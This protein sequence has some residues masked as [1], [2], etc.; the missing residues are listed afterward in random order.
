MAAS[1]VG[2]RSLL[3]HEGIHKGDRFPCKLCKSKF[4]QK[5]YLSSHMRRTHTKEKMYGC[6]FCDK[7]FVTNNERKINERF[8]TGE[9]PYKCDVCNKTFSTYSRKSS[10]EK[11]FKHH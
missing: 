10:H 8:H 2:K 7:Y 4:S 3:V 5:T 11:N 6:Q 1:I 9:K